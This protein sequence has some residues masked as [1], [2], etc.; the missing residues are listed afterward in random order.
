MGA[1]PI[2]DGN[3]QVYM[4]LK[5]AKRDVASNYLLLLY[6]LAILLFI[7]Y[8]CDGEPA[9]P[10]MPYVCLSNHQ[11]LQKASQMLCSTRNTAL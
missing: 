3:M 4:S 1:Q 8:Q 5:V 9:A 7:I 10:D 6:I 2:L 11:L